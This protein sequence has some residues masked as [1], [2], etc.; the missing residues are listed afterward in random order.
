MS[1]AIAGCIGIELIK[2]QF[3]S[4]PSKGA[5][6]QTVLEYSIACRNGVLTRPCKTAAPPLERCH[7]KRTEQQGCLVALS[8]VLIFLFYLHTS[9]SFRSTTRA[10]WHFDRRANED[11]VGKMNGSCTVVLVNE[12]PALSMRLEHASPASSSRSDMHLCFSS[13]FSFRLLTRSCRQSPHRRPRPI[14]HVCH[15]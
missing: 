8:A 5:Q 15:W 10:R 11:K 6:T 2:R 3:L 1:H 9:R 13:S 14:P 7:W 4:G 12:G